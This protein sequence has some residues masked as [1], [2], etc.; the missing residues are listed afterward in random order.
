MIALKAISLAGLVLC[1]VLM[2]RK[3][4]QMAASTE[5]DPVTGLTFQ[6]TWARGMEKKNLISTIIIGVVA[7]FFESR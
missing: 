3:Q 2:I 5:K 7:N 4:K 1:I 6:E